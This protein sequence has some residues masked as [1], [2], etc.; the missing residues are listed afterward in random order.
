MIDIVYSD[1]SLGTE[2]PFLYKN[3]KKFIKVST[4]ILISI[5]IV[6][7]GCYKNDKN[8]RTV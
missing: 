5:M 8:L 1:Q 4:I 2:H 6:T 3:G 7:Y